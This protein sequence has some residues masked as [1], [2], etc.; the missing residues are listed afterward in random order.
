M[1]ERESLTARSPCQHASVSSCIIMALT[2][3][4]V[5]GVAIFAGQ[6]DLP[7]ILTQ[8]E[9]LSKTYLERGQTTSDKAAILAFLAAHDQE[10]ASESRYLLAKVHLLFDI[11][12][13]DRALDTFDRVP[14]AALTSPADLANRLRRSVVRD[15]AAALP[16]ARRLASSSLPSFV[17]WVHESLA[18]QSAPAMK[19]GADA[20]QHDA[21]LAALAE[22]EPAASVTS[23]LRMWRT[24]QRTSD[25]AILRALAAQPLR[26]PE[27]YAPRYL[28]L[29]AGRFE[30]EASLINDGRRLRAAVI[31][32]VRK[33]LES[34]PRPDDKR[35]RERYWLAYAYAAD[36]SAARA[37]G[38]RDAELTALRE[39][40][41]FSP[42][43]DDHRFQYRFVYEQATLGGAS[44]Y[45]S[46]FA[47]ALERTGRLDEALAQRTAAA[48]LDP[49]KV[50]PLQRLFTRLRPSQ[51]FDKYW[52]DT[53]LAGRPT[54]PDF[55]LPTPS[56]ATI[57]LT[58][59][60][61][62]WVLLDFWG[63]WC[64]PCQAEM[65]DVDALA[66]AHPGHVLTVAMHDT[67]ATVTRYM[68]QRG[69]TFPV[70]IGT[71]VVERAFAVPYYPFKVLVAPDGRLLVVQN[72]TW[73]ADLLRYLDK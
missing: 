25:L 57:S 36:A 20:P 59:F 26:P 73:R 19:T 58:S 52:I 31:A 33:E 65:P 44:E 49:A 35:P 64:S 63:T 53:Q 14:D 32:A 5:L 37:A 41:Q 51:S 8:A 22:S 28:L 21:F 71:E 29:L 69:F 3:A 45:R 23:A 62:R 48:Q 34:L 13:D 38:N 16:L 50:A 61:G 56:G 24:A 70:A 4:I 67:A 47:D 15:P 18:Q 2:A 66:R 54:A 12:E 7:S 72:E 68:Q 60:R 9:A 11:G 27:A 39:A 46:A 1:G 55:S 17:R 42:D 10:F 30:T 40:A 6:T 43:A